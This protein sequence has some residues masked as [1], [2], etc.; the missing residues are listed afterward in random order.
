MF[1]KCFLCYIVLRSCSRRNISSKCSTLSISNEKDVIS[2]LV[3]LF[4]EGGQ[5]RDVCGILV[6]KVEKT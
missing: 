4:N 6:Y 3:R 5:M 1:S 2:N